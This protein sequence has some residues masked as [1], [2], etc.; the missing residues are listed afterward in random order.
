MSA[1]PAAT[2]PTARPRAPL[3]RAVAVGLVLG[4]LLACAAEIGRMIVGR[5]KH[6]VVPGRV[7]RTAQLSPAQ[8]EAFVRRYGIRTVVNLR[9]RPFDDWYPA[10]MKATQ[11]LGI[12]QEDVTTSANRL[13][14]PG[15]IRR[16]VEVF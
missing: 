15:E 6:V 14:S 5:N 2:Q 11:A 3:A 4:A 16:L 8:L 12:S 10:E 1:V 13:P 9:G 7:Y